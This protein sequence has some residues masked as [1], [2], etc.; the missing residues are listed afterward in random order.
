MRQLFDKYRR[1]HTRTDHSASPPCARN[2][3]GIKRRGPLVR[4]VGTGMMLSR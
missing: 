4:A 1:T 2:N 3:G